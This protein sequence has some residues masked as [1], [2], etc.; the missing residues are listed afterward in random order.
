M[1]EISGFGC[2]V[3]FPLLCCPRTQDRQ[4]YTGGSSDPVMTVAGRQVPKTKGREPFLF[5]SGAVILRI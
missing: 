4:Y 3:L 5:I 1:E 2:F